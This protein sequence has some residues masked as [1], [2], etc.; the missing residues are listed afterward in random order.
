M[1]YW[2]KVFGAGM[3]FMV[4]GPLG[5]IIGGALGHAY[6]TENEKK[7]GS[8]VKCPH[9]GHMINLSGAADGHCPVCGVKI[10]FQQVGG[11]QDRQF[12]FYVSLASLAA[13]MAKA[14]GVVTED[15]VHAFD[16]FVVNNLR[17][18]PEDRKIIARLFNEA[19]NSRDDA[20][21]IALQFKNL[22]GYQTDVLQTMIQL[23]FNIAMADGR[24]HPAEERFIKEVSSVFG[25][26]NIQYE[27]VK[28]LYIK[29]NSHAYQILG[30]SSKA[31][32]EEVKHAYKKLAREYH[33]DML[34]SKGVPKDFIS[35]ANE[36]MKEIN[37]AYDEIEKE[38]GL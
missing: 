22:I 19:K 26:S 28:A 31:S 34:I 13:K 36:K 8:K 29:T 33:P 1:G 4:G 23:L 17:V 21:S 24:F 27:Q 16:Q 3:G 38:R 18:S 7:G 20:K 25:L 30:I 6:D 5:A 15:E 11:S 37:N 35:F 10:T 9:C 32:N 2:G 12:L 14:D